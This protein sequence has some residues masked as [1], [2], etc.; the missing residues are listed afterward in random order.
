[1]HCL[2]VIDFQERLVKHIQN[3]EDIINNSIKLIKAYKVFGLPILITEQKKLGG[4]IGVIKDLIDV[5]PIQKMSFSCLRCEEFYREFKRL[6]PKR[7]A[8]I[9]IEAHIC[10]LQ[11]ALDLLKEGCEV[12]VAVDCIGSRKQIDK[13]VAVLRMMQEGVKL[14]TAESLIYEIMKTAEHEK[15]KEILEIVKG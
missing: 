14:C 15:F 11:T 5:K 2:I 10:I 3:V 9:G 13:D 1:M 12:Y 7:V 4:T 6:S 8:L